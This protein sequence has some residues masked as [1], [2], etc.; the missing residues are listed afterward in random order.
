[1]SQTQGSFV[2]QKVL[3]LRKQGFPLVALYSKNAGS[4]S[5]TLVIQAEGT[6]LDVFL[7]C[8]LQQHLSTLSAPESIY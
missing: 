2:L 8:K 6:S 4:I 5:E 3:I 1:M 7:H